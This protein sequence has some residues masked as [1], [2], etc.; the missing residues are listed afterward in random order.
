MQIFRVHIENFGKLQDLD[1]EF[2]AGLTRICADNGWGKSTLA[3]FIKAMFYGLAY[4]TKRSLKEN[5]RKRYFPW[6]GG[7][8]GGNMEFSVRS[9]RYRVERFF[10]AKDKEDTFALYDLDTGLVSQ[11]YSVRLGEELFGVDRAA[12]ERSSFFM[13]QDFAVAINDSLGA[14]LT[15]TSQAAGDLQHY[16]KAVASL[17]VQMKY[18][19][20]TGNRGLLGTL[21][22]EKRAVQEELSECRRQEAA[23]EEWNIQLGKIEQNLRELAEEKE[24]LQKECQ[25]AQASRQMESKRIQYDRLRKEAEARKEELQK[26]AEALGEF[27]SMPPKEEELERCREQL[28]QLE[29][30]K[31]QEAHA[32]EKLGEANH[33]LSVLEEGLDAPAFSMLLGALAGFLPILGGIFCVKGNVA[34]GVILLVVGGILL[35][36]GG[37]QSYRHQMQVKKRKQQT[38]AA[39]EKLRDCERELRSVRKNKEALEKKLSRFLKGSE[40]ADLV[41]LEHRWKQLR[42]ESRQYM[43]IKQIYEARRKE[44]SKSRELWFQYGESLSEEERAYVLS[45]EGYETGAARLQEELARCESAWEE[46]TKEQQGIHQQIARLLEGAEQIPS[47][48]EEKMRLSEQI[49]DA[50]QEYEILKKTIQYLEKAREQFSVRYLQELQERLW[51]YLEQLIPEEKPEVSLDIKLHL[52]IQEAGA[53]RSLASFSAGWQDLLSFAERL[54]IVDVLYKEERPLLLFDD[55]FV[56]L[57]E[58]KQTRVKE[59]LEMLAKQGQIFYFTCHDS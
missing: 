30:L 6:Q 57:D 29:T 8:F 7:A 4:T 38:Q 1:M 13:Q 45:P 5:E 31:Q 50:T 25:M 17:E 10:G 28:Y 23:I 2:E 47:L 16:E 59:L 32:A 18:L 49:Q 24:A 14:G 9:K 26:A 44:A 53:L 21:T 51:Y 37:W 20:K 22:E 41:E 55:P 42:E 40:R 56:N 27:T 3:A 36:L 11:D 46:L 43:E 33:R 52:K 48:E 39:E 12:Y 54:A 15:H 58:G 19:Q 34:A 35:L